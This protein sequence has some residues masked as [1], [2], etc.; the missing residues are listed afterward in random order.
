ML[1]D[2]LQTDEETNMNIIS[3]YQDT[4]GISTRTPSVI[5]QGRSQ[6]KKT[7][8]MWCFLS[9]AIAIKRVVDSDWCTG[10]YSRMKANFVMG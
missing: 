3:R 7:L 9:L 6:W 2:L 1:L 4:N 5:E 10:T 8:L